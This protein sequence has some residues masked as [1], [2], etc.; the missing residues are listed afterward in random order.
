MS[1]YFTAM[2]ESIGRTALWFTIITGI[3]ALVLT[4]IQRALHWFNRRIE[5]PTL[6]RATAKT[7]KQRRGAAT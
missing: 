1:S 6:P 5:Q 3:A 4:L 7:Q 2:N